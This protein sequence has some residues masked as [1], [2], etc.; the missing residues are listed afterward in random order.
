M[1]DLLDPKNDY[2]FKRLFTT[3]PGSISQGLFKVLWGS[4]LAVDHQAPQE[5]ARQTL[6][7]GHWLLRQRALIETLKW[8]LRYV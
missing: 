6:V 1:A 8:I 5:H 7:P 3:A 4:R 2:V